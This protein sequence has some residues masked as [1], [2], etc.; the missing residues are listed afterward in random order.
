MSR[1]AS[2]LSP[3]GDEPG[4]KPSYRAAE[5]P[6]HFEEN[7]ADTLSGLADLVGQDMGDL[8][9][10]RLLPGN[11]RVVSLL[12]SSQFDDVDIQRITEIIENR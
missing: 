10:E 3:R 5:S 8:S 6:G 4:T 7:A 1:P 9:I 11:A 2:A 12:R